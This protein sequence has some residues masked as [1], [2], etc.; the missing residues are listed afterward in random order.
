MVPDLS[1]ESHVFILTDV[2]NEF[3]RFEST[4]LANSTQEW[5][6]YIPIRL[7]TIIEQFFRAMIATDKIRRRGSVGKWIS[8]ST[9]VDIC[10]YHEKFQTVDDNYADA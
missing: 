9:L 4:V 10:E 1:R 5:Q 3:R 2:K 8:T 6:N 7:A